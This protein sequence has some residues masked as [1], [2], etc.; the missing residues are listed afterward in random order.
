[1]F[2]STPLARWLTDTSQVLCKLI[3][4]TTHT[5]IYQR[6]LCKTYISTPQFTPTYTFFILVSVVQF[7]EKNDFP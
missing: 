5:E 7:G 3:F 1:M 6:D 4:L 2:L